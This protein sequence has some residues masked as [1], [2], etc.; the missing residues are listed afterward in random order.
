MPSAESGNRCPTL[1]KHISIEA[2]VVA[3]EALNVPFHDIISKQ[4]SRARVSFARQVAMYL[5]HVV[6][7]MTLGEVSAVFERDRTTVGYACHIVEDR[8]DAPMFDREMADLE[9]Q[10]KTRL[11]A[12]FARGRMSEASGSVGTNIM[13]RAQLRR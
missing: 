10:F 3:S 4:R 13:R 1:L 6:G 5:A 7:E 11:A 2:M 12:L 8:R 9:V